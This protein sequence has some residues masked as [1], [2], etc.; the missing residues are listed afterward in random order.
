MKNKKSG[1]RK[2]A[3]VKPKAVVEAVQ[4]MESMETAPKQRE[5]GKHSRGFFVGLGIV[6]GTSFGLPF[7]F[8][9]ANPNI[10]WTGMAIGTVLGT[11]Y[12]QKYNHGLGVLTKQ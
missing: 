4:R 3:A 10:I 8:A 12:E 2:K 5:K 1:N 7:G 6:A 11:V 9:V